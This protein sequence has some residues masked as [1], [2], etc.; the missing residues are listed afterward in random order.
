[1][2]EIFH[3]AITTPLR[4]Q[5]VLKLLAVVGKKSRQD[6]LDLLQPKAISDNQTK[7]AD[8]IKL[9]K[10]MNM[11]ESTDDD[12]MLQLADSVPS[13]IDQIEVYRAYMQERVMGITNPNAPNNYVFNQFAAWLAVQDANI[14]NL[15]KIEL[16]AK[17]SKEMYPS[18]GNE[19]DVA[20]R[21]MNDTKFNGWINWATFLG[22]GVIQDA[23]RCG[24][25]PDA[26][27][28]LRGVLNDVLPS[29]DAVTMRAFMEKLVV[30]C[31]ELDGGTL[32]ED[33][34]T[35]SRPNENRSNSLSFMLSTG[36]R[37]L[38]SCGDVKLVE[39]P[40]SGDLWQL[41]PVQGGM[42]RISHIQRGKV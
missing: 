24:F 7:A 32:F 15:N 28:R 34:W 25:V 35:L 5:V 19:S 14:V 20:T 29:G 21:A 22:W 37:V 40:D 30:A 11:I 36:L 17:F 26:S 27:G 16:T 33:A 31:P 2:A 9:L 38:H 39:M 13:K 42:N 41:F 23:F 8:A 10:A 12:Q 18:E 3:A 6:I 4:L 1:M